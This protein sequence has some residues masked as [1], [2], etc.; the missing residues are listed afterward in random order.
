[1]N[2]F[3]WL[4]DMQRN[5]YYDRDDIYYCNCCA[6]FYDI[7]T[8]KLVDINLY[9]LPIEFAGQVLDDRMRL[10]GIKQ[11]STKIRRRPR[12]FVR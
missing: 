11:R 1:M 10:D 12:G 8:H 9:D 5:N 3:K 6:S 4:N 7:K 2:G